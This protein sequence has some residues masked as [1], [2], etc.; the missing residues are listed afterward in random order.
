MPTPTPSPATVTPAGRRLRV[1]HTVMNMNYGGM[2]RLIADL[3][4]RTDPARFECH[5]L[6]LQYAGR[7]AEGLEPHARVH[8]AAPLPS[9]TMLW[10]RPLAR[11][12]AAIAPDVV[13]SHSGVW[14]K[15]A[16]AARLAG[17]PR[18]VH[19][20]H[21]WVRS[22]SR[23]VALALKKL[24][25]RCST[26]IVAVSEDLGAFLASTIADRPDKVQ[27]VMNGVDV[28]HF[29]PRPDDGALRREL[30]IAAE[31]PIIL[32]V[33]RL[34][35]VKAH[36]TMLRAFARLRGGRGPG[37]TAVLLLVGDGAENDRLQQLT[38]ELGVSEA[39]R[40]AGWRNDVEAAHAA[41]ALFTLTSTSEGTSI[42]LLEA[43][44]AGVCP[45]VSDVG[46]NAAVLGPGL[47]HRLVPSGD[48]QAIAAGWRDALA[49]EARRRG[50]ARAA[51]ARVI[52]RFS[53]AATVRQYEKI[54]AAPTP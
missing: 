30:G 44:S 43:M 34:E 28:D 25:A 31:A 26:D 5:L 11:Q 14:W 38:S 4:R 36:D 27:V 33:G 45:V 8:Q 40:F 17:V 7:F 2:E 47:A 29:A 37:E 50:D 42:A 10:P 51:R 21:G 23:F 52:E 32:S 20:E 9:W 49:D 16:L 39:V 53:I 19:T 22:E 48:V 1:L 46:G 12:I 54:Y 6:V 15:S 35:A 3:I 18:I 13:H 24:S 41:A